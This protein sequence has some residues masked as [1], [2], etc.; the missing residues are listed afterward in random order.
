MFTLMCD[1]FIM[2]FV[3]SEIL[4]LEEED[5]Y[6]RSLFPSVA[7]TAAAASAGV[8]VVVVVVTAAGGGGGCCCW[9]LLRGTRGGC[10]CCW[11]LWREEGR[12]LFG[13]NYN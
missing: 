11:W 8:V 9:L 5:E 7:A 4:S 10:C 1:I 12:G 6:S 3:L 13:C 2:C